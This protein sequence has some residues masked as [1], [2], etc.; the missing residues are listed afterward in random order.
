M[1]VLLLTAVHRNAER[2]RQ[3]LGCAK[4]GR[5]CRFLPQPACCRTRCCRS[6]VSLPELGGFAVEEYIL[7]AWPILYCAALAHIGGWSGH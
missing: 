1:P 7:G 3:L 2:L 4:L 6:P 5:S